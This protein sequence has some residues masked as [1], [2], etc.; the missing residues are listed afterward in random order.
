MKGVKCAQCGTPDVKGCS[1]NEK[2]HYCSLEHAVEHQNAVVIE[3]PISSKGGHVVTHDRHNQ[4]V[5]R[6]HMKGSKSKSHRSMKGSKRKI[7]NAGGHVE[8]VRT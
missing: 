1:P 2:Y 3:R 5:R 6:K 8:R 7:K 4:R